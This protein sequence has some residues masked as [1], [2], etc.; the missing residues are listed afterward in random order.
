MLASEN[1][2]VFKPSDVTNLHVLHSVSALENDLNL[3]VL[4]PGQ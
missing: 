2:N 1:R 4:H 3:A